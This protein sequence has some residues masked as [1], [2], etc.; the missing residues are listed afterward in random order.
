MMTLKEAFTQWSSLSENKVLASKNRNN[1]QQVLF[2]KHASM[3]VSLIDRHF[4]DL[5]LKDC[6][7]DHRSQVNACSVICHVM[8]WLH[9]KDP[10]TYPAPDF[11]YNIASVS[12][13]QQPAKVAKSKIKRV[14]KA[15]PVEEQSGV[16]EKENVE[17]AEPLE[18]TTISENEN[19]NNISDMKEIKV[20]GKQP[21][22]VVQL[23]P[24][25]YE[26]IKV[27]E[28]R[29]LAERELGACNLDRAISRKR[30]S[31]GFFWCNPE[32]VENFQ[33]NPNSQAVKTGKRNVGEGQYLRRPV[34]QIDA[35]TH[36]E[37]ARFD[38]A[39][40]AEKSLSIRNVL[41]AIDRCG[42]AGGFY[43]AF[44]D[45]FTP[46]WKPVKREKGYRRVVPQTVI[47]SHKNITS[48]KPSV[49]KT[50]NIVTTP[51]TLTDKQ[52]EFLS[53]ISDDVLLEEI[54]RRA[55]WHGSVRIDVTT[56]INET[57]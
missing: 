25:T 1:M 44:A 21:I 31:V 2:N 8:N 39:K 4:M 49:K 11:D 41:R 46:D 40:A 37:I 5:V 32:D 33:P 45:E 24:K 19:H 17:S 22:P 13:A 35:T 51:K 54:R 48:Q 9:E 26:V 55:N 15:Q 52:R 47:N 36:Q 16:S 12:S 38:T 6:K 42:V 23:D 43:W 10:K 29:S 28:S 20:R 34:V 50:D 57:F 14:V 30:M 56:T 27:W 18:T 53:K 3:D 7:A